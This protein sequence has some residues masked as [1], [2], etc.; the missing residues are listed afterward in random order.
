MTKPTIN[1]LFLITVLSMPALGQFKNLK[2]DE[3]ATPGQAYEPSVA[4]N[5]KDPKNIVVSA[6]PNNIYYTIDG[7][8]TWKKTQIAYSAPCA[9]A[10]LATDDKDNFYYFH[11]SSATGP[12]Q[13]VVHQSTDGGAT[14]SEGVP[15]E[16]T[17]TKDNR[18]LSVSTDARGS[19]LATWTQ[20]DQYADSSTECRSLI[21]Y[22]KSSNGR[23]WSEPVTLSQ[24]PGM[25]HEG[26]AMAAG[27]SAG[28]SPDG[29]VYALWSRAGRLFLDRSFNGGGL[30]LSTDIPVVDQQGGWHLSIEGH[31]GGSGQPQLI[32]DYSK[33][34]MKGSLYVT[35][36]D[37][38]HGQDDTDV[39]FIRSHNGGDHWTSPQR[40][41]SNE[42]GKDQYMPAMS[43]DQTTGFIYIVYLD[44]GAYKDAQ[45]DV[46]LAHSS[47][48]GANF[49]TTKISEAPFTPDPSVPYGD[50]IA[51]A[52]H[53][54]IITPVWTRVDQGKTSI[55]T[56]I[57]PQEQ[58]IPPPV[59]TKKK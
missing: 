25:C 2:L 20:A 10:S 37:Q 13:I 35:F 50:Y 6:Y 14:W 1:L 55:C 46:Y 24:T 17:L 57:I 19:L 48:G 3:P 49:K 47:D 21:V 52:A 8:A 16:Y 29:K 32:V 18:R 51:V 34:M 23:K 42:A 31:T 30:W 15:I 7:G 26:S 44:R 4:I 9:Q 28:M 27:S 59:A 11:L 12:S 53:K 56:A 36:A 45:T 38:R 22:S 43:V 39:W 5:K 41:G 58:L 33:N 54:G 40:I